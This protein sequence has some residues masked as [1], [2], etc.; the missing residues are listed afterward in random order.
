MNKRKI[1]SVLLHNWQLKIYAV[2]VG[3][4]LWFYVFNVRGERNHLAQSLPVLRACQPVKVQAFNP[5]EWQVIPSAV[6][7]YFIPKKTGYFFSR[8]MLLQVFVTPE[9]YR[10]ENSTILPVRISG[11]TDVVVIKVDPDRVAVYRRVK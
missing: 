3:I 11:S 7:V 8:D 1:S 2:L 4:A 5:S 9:E 10:E 6:D